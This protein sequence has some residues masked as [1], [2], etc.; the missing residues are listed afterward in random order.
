[1]FIPLFVNLFFAGFEPFGEHD[2]NASW[3]AVQVWTC[4]LLFEWI[5]CVTH[6][7]YFIVCSQELEGLGLDETADLFVC[8]V[9]VEYQAVQSLLP[10]LWKERNPQVLKNFLLCFAWNITKIQQLV[11]SV[12]CE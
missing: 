2:V 8:E 12:F 7:F 5:I 4:K 1:M 6:C 3:V 11:C 10:V 9:P